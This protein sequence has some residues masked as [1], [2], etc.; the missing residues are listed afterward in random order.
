MLKDLSK[1]QTISNYLQREDIDIVSALH[2]VD[3]TVKTL[4]SMQNETVFKNFYDEAAKRT[5]E[6]DIEITT[7]KKGQQTPG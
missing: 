5:E 2:V 3:S 4:E 6:V 7:S 1:R